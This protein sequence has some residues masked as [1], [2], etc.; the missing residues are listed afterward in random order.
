MGIH[1]SG[2]DKIEVSGNKNFSQSNY[3]DWAKV[4]TGSKVFPALVNYICLTDINIMN[5][6]TCD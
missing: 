4:C 1:P 6:F 2:I 3:I 5:N